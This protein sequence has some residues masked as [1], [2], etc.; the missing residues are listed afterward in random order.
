ME[1]LLQ[2]ASNKEIFIPNNAN[3]EKLFKIW[4]EVLGVKKEEIDINENF[5]ASGGNSL[6]AVILGSKIQ[7]E[8]EIDIP[9]SEMYNL[10]EFKALASY[11]EQ[12]I[13]ETVK[14]SFQSPYVMLLNEKTSQNIFAFPPL[15][16]F[17]LA[18]K[19]LSGF[20]EGH[21]LYSFDFIEEDDRLKQYV[22]IITSIQS[23]GP[24]NYILYS[25]MNMKNPVKINVDIHLIKSPLTGNSNTRKW[26]ALAGNSFHVHTGTGRH[27]DMIEPKYVEKN[28]EI[29]K[30]ILDGIK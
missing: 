29:I 17:G 15:L 12:N 25:S 14:R 21:S 20:L 18:Y 3:E 28:A 16:G 4:Q 7:E 5:F 30:E 26:S 19:N 11:I 24:Y 9:L 1:K 27:G 23:V 2:N 10:S 13:A 6:K 8:F 22:Q